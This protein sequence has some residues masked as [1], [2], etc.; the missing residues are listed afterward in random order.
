MV[1][2]SKPID[3]DIQAFLRWWGSELAFLVPERVQ[4]LLGGRSSWIFLTWQADALEAVLRTASTE[5]RL[6][7]FT[8][9]AAGREAWQRLLEAEP[10]LAEVRMVFRLLPEQCMTRVIKLPLATEENLQ[11]V[12]A[13]ELDR[14][15]PFKPG[16]VY[17]GARVIER[18]KAAGQIR[19]DLA[20]VPKDR[21]DL[22]LEAMSAAGWHPDYADVSENLF[23][24][25]HQLLPERFQVKR[26]RWNRWLNGGLAAIAVGLFLA[27]LIVPVWKKSQWVDQ[28]ETEV[29]KAG[30][31]A[32]E[33]EALRQ[34][35]EQ[36]AHEMGYLAEKKRKD[37]LVLDV[38]N[39]L[40]KVMPDD[41]WLNGF[42]YK[43]GHLVVQGQSPSA[44]SLIARME[45]SAEFKNTSFVSPVTK[46]V[47]NGL[48]RFQIASDAVNGRSSETPAQPENPGQ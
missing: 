47:S 11:Q 29:R 2:F 35:A 39:E 16:Q 48:E 12:V 45:A 10:D 28:L 31:A 21:L 19:V 17:F 22:M 23:K 32:K 30:K 5:R 9:D 25:M 1:D 38:L 34:E 4:S 27:L 20:V 33:V 36:K 7:S 40:S 3:L 15:T 42:Q 14:L 41:T 46:D 13:F 43:D 37:P 8:L 18:L 44:S 26:S 24:R 6:G